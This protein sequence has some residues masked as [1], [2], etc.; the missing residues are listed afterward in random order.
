M[1]LHQL[2]AIV[3]KHKTLGRGHG[4]RGG[5][6]GRGMKGQKSRAGYSRKAGFEG[7]QTPLYMRLPK[8]RGSKQ[9]F[10][11]QVTKPVVITIT[12]L[13]RFA[14]K[15]IVGP[16]ALRKA[17]YLESR[18]DQVKVIGNGKMKK[19]ITLRVHR[20]SEGARQ[21]VEAAGG[22]VEIIA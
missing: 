5:K 10:P 13:D 8:G 14:N 4:K 2:P 22:K 15:A 3:R 19:E 17:G 18:R 20:I 9:K 16:A 11:S 7:G 1:A 21:A 6:S 12:V